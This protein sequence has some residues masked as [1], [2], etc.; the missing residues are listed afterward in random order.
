MCNCSY[1]E[2]KV[3]CIFN[4]FSCPLSFVPFPLAIILNKLQRSQ[5][6]CSRWARAP[7]PQPLPRCPFVTASKCSAVPAPHNLG[8]PVSRF[9]S[10]LVSQCPGIPLSQCPGVIVSQCSSVLVSQCP[11]VLVSQWPIV[12]VSQRH[13]VLVFQCPGAQ[14]P[15]VPVF[16]CPGVPLPWCLDVPVPVLHSPGAEAHVPRHKEKMVELPGTIQSKPLR[17]NIPTWK[18]TF[19]HVFNGF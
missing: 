8:V 6:S 17:L 4:F 3:L 7:Q 1:K 14:Y 11:G 15:G 5:H 9:P 13:G 2:G 19:F 12:P 10:V 16:L 18:S